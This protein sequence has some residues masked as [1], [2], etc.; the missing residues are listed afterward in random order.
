VIANQHFGDGITD[1]VTGRRSL[2]D[3]DALLTQWRSE[4]G[5]QVRHEYEE[6]MAAG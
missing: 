5:D 1:I 3:L 2:T 6:A 4:G